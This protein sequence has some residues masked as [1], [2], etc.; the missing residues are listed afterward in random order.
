MNSLR[1]RAME[2][3]PGM[4]MVLLDLQQFYDTH[5]IHENRQGTAGMK[6]PPRV[7]D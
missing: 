3:E 6:Y 2:L 1:K 7:V 4:Y 5:R